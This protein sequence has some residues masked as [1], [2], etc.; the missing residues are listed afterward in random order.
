[1]GSRPGASDFAV[2]GQL[3]Q[4]AH[5]DPTPTRLALERA[6]RVYAWVDVM[7][8]LSGLDPRDDDWLDSHALPATLKDMLRLAG[9]VYVPLLVANAAAVNAGKARVETE[10]DGAPWVQEPNAYQAKCLLWLRR[11]FAE[12]E[13]ADAAAGRALLAET[14]CS[15]LLDGGV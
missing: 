14:G 9:R 1:M 5:F 2:F 12:L 4:L 7:E 13:A 6:P 3:T 11:S 10:I 8:D 15:F